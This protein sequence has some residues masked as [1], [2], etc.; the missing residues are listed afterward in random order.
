MY[1]SI[2]PKLGL[3]P[4]QLERESLELFLQHRLR[5]V[6]SHLLRL[7]GKFGVQTIAELDDLVQS[8]RVHEADAF[9]DYFEFDRLEAK[10][11]ALVESLEELA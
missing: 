4:R 1:E 2:A 10:R 11:G 5:L 6:E 8:G 9:E 7:A 3:T